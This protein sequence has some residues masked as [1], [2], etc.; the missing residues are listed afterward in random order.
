MPADS[1]L[2]DEP[3][4]RPAP[5]KR[6]GPIG[7]LYCLLIAFPLALALWWFGARGLW[8]FLASAVAIIPLAGLMGRSTENLAHHLGPGLGGFLNATFGNAAELIIALLAL[9][10]GKGE[11][12]KASITGSIIG[13]LL[14]VLGLS[15]LLGGLYHPR[16][17]F[18][19]NAAGLG[20][21]L[22]ALACIGL[23]IPTAYYHLL[24]AG[25]RQAGVTLISD[26]I[27]VILAVSYL[28]SL[29][30]SLWTH[31]QL[32]AGPQA[33]VER[34]Q[35]VTWSA[36]TAVVVLVIATAG[37]ALMSEC[38]VGSVE[39][40]ARALGMTDLFVGI[41]VVAVI[42]NAA[43]HSTAV[44]AALKDKMDLAFTIAVGSSFQV[45][46]FVAPVLVGASYLVGQAPLDLH[47]TPLEVVAVI[48]SVAILSRV[49]Q[50]GESNWLEGALLLAVYLILALAFYHAPVEQKLS[51][52]G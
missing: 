38:L 14:L 29:V 42:G 19:R 9:T 52:A 6:W 24:P 40:A 3:L 37:V 30:F 41:I 46:L 8:L 31:R 7:P 33:E 28:L 11:L 49:S 51:G 12:V 22:L 36:R 26:E 50:D 25:Q 43:E 34:G 35:E 45:A 17:T 44:L 47:F 10:N 5:G 39:H 23:V 1:P 48:L 4:L 18:N 27:A 16:Q 21:T 2:L 13:N 15:V 32:F 20:G